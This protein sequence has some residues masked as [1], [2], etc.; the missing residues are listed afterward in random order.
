MASSGKTSAPPRGRPR[1]CDDD[2]ILL[3]G[4][5]AFAEHGY[6]AM[7]LHALNAGLGLS[8]G[9]IN[10]RFA[11]KEQ[12]WYAA[13]DYGF[14]HLVADISGELQRRAVP[15]DDL[16]LLRGNIRAFLVALSRHPELVR[17]INQEGVHPSER[18][19]YILT[20]FVLPALSESVEAMNRL[21]D[22]K[23]LR[24]IPAR[25]LLFLVVHGA[26]APFTLQPLSE[27]FDPVDGALDAITHVELMT[28]VII[29]G[30][31]RVVTAKGSTV[32]ATARQPRVK[33]AVH[34]GASRIRRG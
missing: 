4:L 23:T 25:T 27:R 20:R 31:R 22:A 12:F 17:L 26:A 2:A 7:S 29:S 9:T 14:R 15:G 8:H 16:S 1:L 5:R 34:E 32:A 33:R 21:A 18:L 19:D 24:R 28:D 10:E 11:S 3:A 30:L 13:V 6:E